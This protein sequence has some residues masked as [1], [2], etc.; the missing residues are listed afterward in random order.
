MTDSLCDLT[1]VEVAARVREGDL[2]P[3]E[4]TQA[5][6]DRAAR[7][8]PRLNCF[9]ATLGEAALRRAEACAR[10][11]REGRPL[12]PLHGVPITLKD[13][14]AT[15]G[16]ETTA[17]SPTLAGSVPKTSA[18]V[19]RRLEE[20]GAVLVAKAHLYEFAY[21]SAHP[22]LGDTRNPWNVACVSGGSSSGSA[23]SVAAGLGFASIGSDTGGS[24]RVPASLCGIVGLKP[25]YGRVS[26]AGI[27]PLGYSLDVAGPLTRSV[28]DAAL[29][30]EV[31]AGHDAADPM[32]A[33]RTVPSFREGIEDGV[34]GLR[35]GVPR[36]QSLELC[37]PDVAKVFAESLAVLE[38]E[39][40][41]LRDVTLPD[42]LA[43]QTI[44]DVL[45]SGEAAEAHYHHVKNTPE[46]I[47]PV[48][49]GRLERGYM[50]SAA[51]YVRAQRARR[52]FIAEVRAAM[53]ELEALV[54]PG[55]PTGTYP[56]DVGSVLVNGQPVLVHPL[57]SRFTRLF[58]L[59][60]DPAI[61]VPCGFTP[62]GMPVSLQFVGRAF[63]ERTI[64]RAARAYERATPWH[65]M[66][67]PL[68]D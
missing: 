17:G 28:T 51:D 41:V 40:A 38:T 58:S 22:A 4:V 62:Q 44:V 37:T 56:L 5:V 59:S 11:V 21:G 1:L 63:D 16:I 36:R 24:I 67:P 7:L 34:R 68:V 20:A 14:V 50:I 43:A 10:A 12:G 2:S 45:I 3:V 60:G 33:R 64:L 27:V 53:S 57:T 13:N 49:R 42:F 47:G 48:V 15:A 25:T 66:R 35:L 30:L 55:H 61:V 23:S 31:I 52:R 65:T 39:G 18:T 29:I 26:R 19:W 8:A 6:L 54:L 9:L 32:T 46:K